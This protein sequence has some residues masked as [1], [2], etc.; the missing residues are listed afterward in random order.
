VAILLKNRTNGRGKS[1]LRDESL[2][3]SE[4]DWYDFSLATSFEELDEY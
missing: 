1:I 2:A 3:K 4:A